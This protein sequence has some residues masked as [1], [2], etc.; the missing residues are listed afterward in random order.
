M[1]ITLTQIVPYKCEHGQIPREAMRGLMEYHN[2]GN[3][4]Y[5]PWEVGA[6]YSVDN[7]GG[8]FSLEDAEKVDDYLRACGVDESLPILINISW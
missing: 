2:A 3:D 1:S 5:V 6:E 4:S 8:W 7:T